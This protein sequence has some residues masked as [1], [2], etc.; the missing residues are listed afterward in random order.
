MNNNISKNLN[1][2]KPGKKKCIHFPPSASLSECSNF[3]F[4]KMIEDKPIVL[5]GDINLIQVTDGNMEM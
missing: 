1:S 3:E 4:K 5:V 2:F